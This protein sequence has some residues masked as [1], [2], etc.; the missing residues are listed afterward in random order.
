MTFILFLFA[1]VMWISS[2]LGRYKKKEW[3]NNYEKFADY[4]IIFIGIPFSI[5]IIAKIIISIV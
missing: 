2:A 3:D 5:F 1:N 4:F